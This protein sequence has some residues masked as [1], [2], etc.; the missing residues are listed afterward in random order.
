MATPLEKLKSLS[1]GAGSLK[2]DSAV[3]QAVSYLQRFGVSLD[4]FHEDLERLE[5]VSPKAAQKVTTFAKQ[6]G[7]VGVEAEDAAKNLGALSEAYEIAEQ[8]LTKVQK[9]ITTAK[10]FASRHLGD[11]GAAAFALK[12]I[13]QSYEAT[14]DATRAAAQTSALGQRSTVEV[15]AAGHRLN[16]AVANAVEG[17]TKYGASAE[18]AVTIAKDMFKLTGRASVEQFE[19]LGALSLSYG[20][21]AQEMFT[22]VQ[23]DMRSHGKTLNEAV[24]DWS[25]IEVQARQLRAGLQGAGEDQTTVNLSVLEYKKVVQE[26]RQ[27]LGE[28]TSSTDSLAR[29]QAS[30]FEW[31]RKHNLSV[32]NT[33][34]LAKSIGKTIELP[35]HLKHKLGK[36]LL[37][38]IQGSLGTQDLNQVVDQFIASGR[39]REQDRQVATSILEDAQ[40]STGAARLQQIQ[41]LAELTQRSRSGALASLEQWR[42]FVEEHDDAM[43]VATVKEGLGLDSIADAAL[44]TKFLR[45]NNLGDA[46]KE[47]RSMGVGVS[48]ELT[49][50]EKE[51]RK[52]AEQNADQ[53]RKDLVDNATTVADD[54]YAKVQGLLR[55]PAALLVASLSTYVGGLALAGAQ[56]QAIVA[57]LA[58][59]QV[60]TAA[61]AGTTAIGKASVLGKVAKVAGGAA[62][63][64]GG[65]QL[66]DAMVSSDDP[67][68]SA[69]QL[70]SGT[71]PAAQG[72]E[73]GAVQGMM[74]RAK[75]WMALSPTASGGTLARPSRDSGGAAANMLQAIAGGGRKGLLEGVPQFF[76]NALAM[77]G[78]V[79]QQQDALQKAL[80]SKPRPVRTRKLAQAARGSQ[81]T[82]ALQQARQSRDRGTVQGALQ[83]VLVKGGDVVQRTADS[84]EFLGQLVD[85]L[86]E[87]SSRPRTRAG[88]RPSTPAGAVSVAFL[89]NLYQGEK[90][91]RDSVTI[92]DMELEA[93]DITGDGALKVRWTN[94]DAVLA[95]AQKFL[96]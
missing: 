95:A 78:G 46:A 49:E 85:V 80:S 12:A 53:V 3:K 70:G 69:G 10:D 11:I 87:R 35:A 14:Q 13:K 26:T 20:V 79:T 56:R 67:G 36:D 17:L 41:A 91:E 88:A 45:S 28:V 2:R 52:D 39:L 89:S 42:K 62:L 43:S 72:T 93:V 22:R 48:G 54:L 25:G 29:V 75:K 5:K 94:P 57:E 24:R 84:S 82:R 15:V 64:Y 76:A 73:A 37:Q 65:Y 55:K 77:A 81:V 31:A 32:S 71:D 86:I 90:N 9:A 16:T 27:E 1:T 74:E 59:L 4:T 96:Q 63:A 38:E 58:A 66:L 44:I 6:L 83:S 51:A 8:R 40:S 23:G 7:L 61:L 47:L 50:A 60:S 33:V 21:T 34:K 30:A 92:P 19:S 18:E 68:K